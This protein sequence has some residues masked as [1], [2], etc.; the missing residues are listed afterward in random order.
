MRLVS[1]RLFLALAAG[2]SL[3]RHT[4]AQSAGVPVR[5]R[6]KVDTVSDDTLHLTFRDG[7]KASVLL[8]A[9]VRVTWLTAA[10]PGDI[11]KG[12]CIGTAAIPQPDGT[13]RALESQVLPPSMRG[14][15]EG[16]RPFDVAPGC[17]MTKGT[18][19][20]MVCANG[21]IL[22]PAKA[23]STAGA[24]ASLLAALAESTR[25]S[26]DI[27]AIND[28][29]RQAENPQLLGPE[30]IRPRRIICHGLDMA[31]GFHFRHRR[32]D[33]CCLIQRLAS[34][35]SKKRHRSSAGDEQSEAS[36]QPGRLG[37]RPYRHRA[38][39]KMRIP[40]MMISQSGRS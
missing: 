38:G 24:A 3:G 25:V 9:H 29:R 4:F 19:G 10:K 32:Q 8:P 22:M 30:P 17:T 7:D 20:N 37:D 21:Q 2:I 28:G 12:S 34:G 35:L 23:A 40:V 11:A 36:A 27:G 15:G 13:L 26:E 1:K 6:G 16:S 33:S 14:V 39:E 18:V 5:L 31:Q